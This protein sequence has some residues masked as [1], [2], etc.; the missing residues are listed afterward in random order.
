MTS[1][2]KRTYTPGLT[3]F[4]DMFKNI[5]DRARGVTFPP[6]NL[7][8]LSDTEYAL[9]MAVAGYTVDELD[10][11]KEGQTIRI[12]GTKQ[13][14]EEKKDPRYIH[15]GIANRLFTR[16]F[17][18]AENVQVKDV[19]LEH[20]MLLI[21]FETIIPEEKKPL[22]LEIKTGQKSSDKQLLNG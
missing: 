19:T 10:I 14:S 2:A 13:K 7:I 18:L 20:G 12:T 21:S 6:Y 4:E 11:V 22:K 3:M 9:E 15:Q 17:N 16:T 1:L 5:E 8:Q